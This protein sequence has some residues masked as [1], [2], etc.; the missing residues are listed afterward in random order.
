INYLLQQVGSIAMAAR[1]RDKRGI[2]QSGI[3]S[4][5]QYI[6]NTQKLQV[7]QSVFGF[8]FG[9]STAKQM[10]NGVHLV[11]IHNGRTNG[12]GTGAFAIAQLFKQAVFML[13]VNKVLPQGSYVNKRRLKFHQGVN[14][15]VQS[16]YAM[17]F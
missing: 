10:R 9:K 17:A 4:Q 15:V 12:N 2:S 16:L 7:D 5:Y 14:S 8:I 3:A 13:F 1:R 11:L 6:F